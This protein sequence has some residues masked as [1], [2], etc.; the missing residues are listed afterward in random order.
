VGSVVYR[1]VEMADMLAQLS[2]RI[3]KRAQGPAI[4]PQTLGPIVGG[5]EDPIT[6]DALYPRW[7][8]FFRR[9]DV[10]FTDTGTSS[11]GLTFAQ[12]PNGAEFHKLLIC[13]S[14]PSRQNSPNVLLGMGSAS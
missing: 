4:A 5:G 6:A 14:G 2:G 13:L 9:D 8:D 10:I 7:A 3:T 12:L 11:L 1:N